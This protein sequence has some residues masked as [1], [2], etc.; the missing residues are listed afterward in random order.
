MSAS[1]DK[2]KRQAERVDGTEKRQVA[3]RKKQEEQRKSRT[4]WTVGTVLVVLLV[5]VILLANSNLF[6]NVVPSVKVGDESYTNAEYQY[7]YYTGYYQFYNN[8]SSYAS[9]LGLDTSQPVS[10]QPVELN[11]LQMFGITV[12]SVMLAEGYKTS[13]TWEDYFN[14]LALQSMTQ[15]TALYEQATAAGYTLTEEDSASIDQQIEQFGE[16]AASQGFSSAKNYIIAAYGRGCN[17]KIVRQLLEMN[18]VAGNYSQDNLDSFSYTPEELA[19]WYDENRNDYDAFTFAYYY[20]TAETVEQP[21]ET[22]EETAEGAEAETES[23]VTPET[24][25]KA[26]ADADAIAAKVT[27]MDSFNAAVAAYSEG[28]APTES[29]NT[30]GGGIYGVYTDWLKDPARASGDVT[31]IEQEDGGYYV[32]LFEMRSAND[33]PTASMRHILINV[34]DED[35]DGEYSEAEIAKTES[36]AKDIYAKWSS[37]EAT[38]DSFAILANE[39][40]DDTG[41]NTNGG[42]YENINKGRM[43]ESINDF[44]FDPAVKPG[45]T[46]LLFN[47]G[48]YTGWHIVYY[49][50]AGEN[51]CDY[52]ADQALR[53]QDYTAW[54]TAALEGYSAKT[55]LVLKFASK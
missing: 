17:E 2:K 21:K 52:L 34:T 43:V 16:Y 46:A 19:A 8:Y 53:G 3:E 10:E 4:R 6:Y 13:P 28:A 24:M 12:P 26:K 9:Y 32:V 23:V 48:S 11:Y 1:Q 35:E 22:T 45:D 55:N 30:Q 7:Y 37:G 33:Y 29:K 5:A 15:V 40:S 31:V 36:I 27:G 47:N 54:Q 49:V 14:E 38:E 20:V 18:Y 44:L 42:L 39:N 41:S 25:A 51:Y 50:G